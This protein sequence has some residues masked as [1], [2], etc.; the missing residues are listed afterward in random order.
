MTRIIAGVA[1][2]RRL[3]VPRSG[4]RPTSDRV[5]EAMFSSIGSWLAARSLAWT[6]VAALDLFAGSG[7]L[8]LE[9]AS[10]GARLALLVERSDRAAS[11]I[12]RNI[13]ACGLDQAQVMVASAMGLPERPSSY[14]RFDL[15]LAD[16]PYDFRASDIQAAL[17]PLG[18]AWLAPDCLVVV[19]RGSGQ[20]ECPLPDDWVVTAQRRYGDTC[21]WYGHMQAGG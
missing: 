1:G 9:A 6:S 5:R 15:C 13:A 18:D 12:R 7:A 2:G 10:R 16:P 14:P 11:V 3:E 20:P 21:L 17:L 4:T 8:G 19:E